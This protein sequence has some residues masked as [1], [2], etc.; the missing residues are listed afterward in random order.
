[1]KK[2]GAHDE[3]QLWF[4][5]Q[6][7]T[8]LLKFDQAYERPEPELAQLEA[9]VAEHRRQH[10]RK[11]L[12]ELA[13]FWLVA[14]IVLTAILGLLD[15]SWIWYVTLQGISAVGAIGFIAAASVK[16]RKQSWKNS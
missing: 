14:A 2:N 1:M 11:L 12:R 7:K 6:V 9:F 13:L 15:R 5:E 3:E 16:R 4:D 8:G 10:R